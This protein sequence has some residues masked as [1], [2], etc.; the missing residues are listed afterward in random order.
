MRVL[1]EKSLSN[2]LLCNWQNVYLSCTDGLAEPNQRSLAASASDIADAIVEEGTSEAANAILEALSE[3]DIE[4]V[5][6]GLIDASR[7][8]FTT[9][10]VISALIAYFRGG[11]GLKLSLVEA[12]SLAL[13]QIQGSVLALSD[14]HVSVSVFVRICTLMDWLALLHK[15]GLREIWA[16]PRDMGNVNT[17]SRPI[18]EVYKNGGES[19]WMK[20][21][22]NVWYNTLFETPSCSHITAACAEKISQH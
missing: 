3:D 15:C 12:V 5:A 9:N 4:A 8:G 20:T 18:A 11:Q 6:D 21:T 19:E 14:V 17:I 2:T 10:A 7:R 22:V 1:W 16:V 13:A